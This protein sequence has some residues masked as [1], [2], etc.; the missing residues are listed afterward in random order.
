MVWRVEE[1]IINVNK[2]KN[3]GKKSSANKTAESSQPIYLVGFLRF[4]TVIAMVLLSMLISLGEP[5]AKNSLQNI[6]PKL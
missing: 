6:T 4:S 2:Y 5:F 3:V 1:L